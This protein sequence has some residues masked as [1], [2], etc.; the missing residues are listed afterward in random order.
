MSHGNQLKSD[1][2]TPVGS[3]EHQRREAVKRVLAAGNDVLVEMDEGNIGAS[4]DVVGLE[5]ALNE[6]AEAFGVEAWFA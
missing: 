1:G 6:L 2:F 3:V 5:A 4:N